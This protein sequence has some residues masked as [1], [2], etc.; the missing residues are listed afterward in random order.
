MWTQKSDYNNFRLLCKLFLD[1]FLSF[2]VALTLYQIREVLSKGR[3]NC[4]LWPHMTEDNPQYYLIIPRY[5]ALSKEGL[6]V[7]RY[8]AHVMGTQWHNGS[9][10]FSDVSDR[11]CTILV[12]LTPDCR[13]ETLDIAS[14]VPSKDVFE[15]LAIHC[16]Q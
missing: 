13:E 1:S 12:H 5:I 16:C 3:R 6:A 2:L 7:C 15:E 11:T 8:K 9:S 4:L 10:F 14:R